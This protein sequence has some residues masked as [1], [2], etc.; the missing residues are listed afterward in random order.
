MKEPATDREWAD[1]LNDVLR[2]LDKLAER[3]PN[4]APNLQNTWTICVNR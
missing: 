2:R 1:Y 4:D 3:K